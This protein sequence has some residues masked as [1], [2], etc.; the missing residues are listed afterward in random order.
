M[1]L[2]QIPLRV[3]DVWSLDVFP[4]GA[5]DTSGLHCIA[6]SATPAPKDDPVPLFEGIPWIA[7]RVIAIP[8]LQKLVLEFP[9][10]CCCCVHFTSHMTSQHS[11]S[12]Q[13]IRVKV[14]DE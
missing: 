2:G 3:L 8:A 13:V 11:L 14:V 10:Y 6:P 7:P 9:N 12:V 5:V 1:T 4:C